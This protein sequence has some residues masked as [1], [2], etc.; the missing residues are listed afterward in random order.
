M[1]EYRNRN[2]FVLKVFNGEG[3]ELID[4]LSHLKKEYE[5]TK[6]DNIAFYEQVN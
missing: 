1:T 5:P 4:N 6:Y 2:H 3:L